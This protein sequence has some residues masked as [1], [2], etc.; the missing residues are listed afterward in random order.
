[1][2]SSVRPAASA[3]LAAVT[4]LTGVAACTAIIG[5]SDL[6][7][8]TNSGADA[9]AEGRAPDATQ[10]DAPKPHDAGVD[11]TQRHDA[12]DASHVVDAE[13]ARVDSARDGGRRDA[14]DAT[15][16]VFV[17]EPTS[18]EFGDA[19]G[20]SGFIACGDTTAPTRRLTV[21]NVGTAPFSW[22][23]SMG[24]GAASPFKLS[25]SCTSTAQCTIAP[26]DA[27]VLEITITGPVAATDAGITSYTD[28]LTLFS[29]PTIDNPTSVKL[30]A[31]SYGAVMTFSQTDINFGQQPENQPDAGYP[32]T[33]ELQNNGNGPFTGTLRLHGPVVGPDGGALDSGSALPA[34]FALTHVAGDAA[35]SDATTSVE[36]PASSATAFTV[37]FDPRGSSASAAGSLFV[38]PSSSP[39]LCAPLPSPVTLEGKGTLS[40]IGVTSSLNFNIGPN[41]NNGAGIS[42]G[43]TG[44]PLAVSISNTSTPTPQAMITSL[45]LALGTASP[46]SVPATPLPIPNG[47]QAA[48]GTTTFLVTPLT[49]PASAIPGTSY[50]DT[51]VVETNVTGDLP[52]AVQLQMTAA[53]VVLVST[54]S[55]TTGATFSTSPFG[56]EPQYQFNVANLGNIPTGQLAIAPTGT[57]FIVSMPNLGPFEIGPGNI[58]FEA[59]VPP[60][61]SV[62][63]TASL[64][65]NVPYCNPPGLPFNGVLTIPLTG[66][67]LAPPPSST[68]LYDS[69]S[70][71][72]INIGQTCAALGAQGTPQTTSITL[73]TADPRGATWTASLSGPGAALFQLSATK[74]TLPSAASIGITLT[75]LGLSST[76]GMTIAEAAIGIGAELD[77]SFTGTDTEV[78]AIPIQEK[79]QGAYLEWTSSTVNVLPYGSSGFS[80]LQWNQMSPGVMLVSGSTGLPI[81][82][83]GGTPRLGN[84][85]NITISDNNAMAGAT[86]TVTATLNA[87]GPLCSPLP[88]PL[89]VKLVPLQ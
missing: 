21:S 46:F 89:P 22:W 44:T 78:Y 56:A 25:T 75:A 19:G 66:Y 79:V 65:S 72:Q 34:E 43:A 7:P 49:I 47:T 76:S 52:H 77:I 55:S 67:S 16:P 88:P 69:V 13:D 4:L 29:T 80:L 12:A 26:G 11:A 1:M 51:L 5:V 68:P 39:G 8:A 71:P 57:P 50:G 24:L 32:E 59:V 70:T 63:S 60:K 45:T 84:P 41:A 31:T 86:T 38:A 6:P 33:A 87:T 2:R 20:K 23:T 53:G 3:A 58:R 61:I 81:K 18:L 82:A 42:C 36:V 62:T 40:P 54:L 64:A 10:A 83:G 48:P 30:A 37:A 17:V 35:T 73:K 27:G 74:G 85:L 14:A 28:T 9:G 15:P